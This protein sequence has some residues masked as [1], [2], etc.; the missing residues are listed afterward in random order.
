MPMTVPAQTQY[1]FQSPA[2]NAANQAALLNL[3]QI[4]KL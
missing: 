4:G 1:G 3:P 2:A